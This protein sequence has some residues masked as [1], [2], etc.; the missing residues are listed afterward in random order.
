[1]VYLITLSECAFATLVTVMLISASIPSLPPDALIAVAFAAGPYPLLALLA[2]R[3]R[4]DRVGSWVLL[5]V[6]VLLSVGGLSLFAYDSYR[7]HTVAEHRMVQR[8]TILVVP[9]L[10]FAVTVGAGLA[11]WVKRAIGAREKRFAISSR[12]DR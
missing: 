1:M 11:L 6:A 12:P 7:Y 3:E 4:G 8:M 2:W 5:S 9:M 10:Q